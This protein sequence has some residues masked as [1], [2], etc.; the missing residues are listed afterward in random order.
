MG[1]DDNSPSLPVTAAD[2]ATFNT[3]MAHKKKLRHAACLCNI[4]ALAQLLLSLSKQG[5]LAWA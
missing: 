5:K 1:Q 2:N 3:T 4:L